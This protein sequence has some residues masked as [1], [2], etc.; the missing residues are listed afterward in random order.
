MQILALLTRHRVLTQTQLGAIIAETPIRTL[1]YRCARLTRHGLA[2]H[3]RPYRERGSA[4]HHLWP[5]RRGEAILTGAPPPRG[6]ERREPNPLFLAH[7]AALSDLY[8]ALATGLP[9]GVGLTRFE[10]ESEAREP[11]DA[12]PVHRPRAVAPDAYVEIADIDGH[13]LGALVELDMGTMSHR[14][15][16]TKAAG[17]ADYARADAWRERHR[18][19]PALLF[20]TTTEK[21]AR[22]LLAAMVKELGREAMLLTCACDLARRPAQIPTDPRWLLSADEGQGA[23]DLLAALREAR[24]PYDEEV[25]RQEAR[26]REEE[27]EAARLLSDPDAL[28]DYL[29]PW[30]GR[31][32]GL[33]RLHAEALRVTL[34]GARPLAGPERDALRVLGALLADPLQVRLADREPTATEHRALDDLLAHHHADQL[35]Q[36]DD[37]ARRLGEGPA[38]RGARDRLE[39]G[40]LLAAPDVS[41]LALGAADDQRSRVE[42]ER[43]RSDYLTWREGEARRRAKGQG[44][45][46]RLR[47]GPDDFLEEIDR[48]S[49]RICRDCGEIA[50]PHPERARY[51]RGLRDVAIRCHFCG[52]GSDLAD[53]EPIGDDGRG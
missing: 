28:R 30:L 22:S 12:G 27:V 3:S 50:Y 43:L 23:V 48:S 42:Q 29:R 26:R 41:A 49:L 8:V 35:R 9:A 10:R 24:R 18:L 39:G 44:L 40:N 52:R 47:R 4:P 16:K 36:V 7:A 1:R 17:Y 21:R 20:I 33:G 15:L 46:A 32:W 19:C 37:L 38:L 11:F 25:A 2:G 45:A 14:R 5:T 6:G 53:Y 34:E 51:E 31:D 13:T